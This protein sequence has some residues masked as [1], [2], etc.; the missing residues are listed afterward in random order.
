MAR[1]I[2]EKLN[3]S[4]DALKQLHEKIEND[5]KSDITVNGKPYKFCPELKLAGLISDNGK[6][7]CMELYGMSY[8]HLFITSEIMHIPDDHPGYYKFHILSKWLMTDDDPE[9]KDFE[10]YGTDIKYGSDTYKWFCSQICEYV[11]KLRILVKNGNLKW[12][13]KTIGVPYFDGCDIE[14]VQ[15]D[16]L[17][18]MNPDFFGKTDYVGLATQLYYENLIAYAPRR[19]VDRLRQKEVD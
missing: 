15:Y 16:R 7:L 4:A 11:K 3:I 10:T 2:P 9:V 14:Y 6:E 17:W 18:H 19:R 13:P 12:D 8:G 5:R 1:P